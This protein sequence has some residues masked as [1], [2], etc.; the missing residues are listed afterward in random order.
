MDEIV[1][2]DGA[3]GKVITHI[4]KGG[5]RPRGEALDPLH[6]GRRGVRAEGVQAAVRRPGCG[7]L[8]QHRQLILVG[9]GRRVVGVKPCEVDLEGVDDEDDCPAEPRPDAAEVYRLL[10]GLQHVSAGACPV[11]L[12]P[13]QQEATHEQVNAHKVQGA[14]AEEQGQHWE[15]LHPAG[16]QVEFRLTCST[17]RYKRQRTSWL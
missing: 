8:L 1:F 15:P 2:Q 11:H 10:S 9:S 5:Q 16:A 14:Y 17:P 12:Q 6:G 7:R 4:H 3:G 13:H